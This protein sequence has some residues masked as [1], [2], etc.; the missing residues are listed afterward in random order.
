MFYQII[1]NGSILNK[2]RLFSA[3]FISFEAKFFTDE[4]PDY[5]RT[6]IWFI[7]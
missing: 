4:L 5:T 1:Q 3:N 7:F 2:A 6:G